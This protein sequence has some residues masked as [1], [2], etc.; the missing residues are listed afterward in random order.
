MGSFYQADRAYLF[1]PRAD[2]WGHWYNSFEWCAVGVQ[3]QREKLQDV[4]PEAVS[5]WMKIFEEDRSVILLNL[6][7]VRD[8]NLTEWRTLTSQGIQRLIA[9]PLRRS[10]R[11][12][13][14]VGVDNPRTC[15][16][17]D[18]QVRVLG[19]FLVT[20]MRAERSE[21]RYKALL[22]ENN[23]VLLEQL[24]VGQWLMGC[25]RQG[26]QENTFLPD[27]VTRQ[28]LAIPE[29]LPPQACFARWLAGLDKEARQQLEEA[30]EQMYRTARAVRVVYRWNHPEKGPV[31]LRFSGILVA[32]TA[33]TVQLRGYC[34]RADK[35]SGALKKQEPDAPQRE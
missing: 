3:P 14:F 25:S 10:G 29:N 18:T 6:D 8:Q 17:D 12:V 4:P 15:I 31:L 22:R 5:R 34:A 27:P 21:Q 35:A 19:S 11:L 33:Q 1:E 7:P 13:G 30:F 24:L 28:M 2:R 26:V 16:H 20:Q 23:D 32:N 9:S